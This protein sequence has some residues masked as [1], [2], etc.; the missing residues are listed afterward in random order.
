[1]S[2]DRPS[3]STSTEEE[4]SESR[5]P[6]V[7]HQVSKRMPSTHLWLKCVKIATAHTLWGLPTMK[8]YMVCKIQSLAAIYLKA[9]RQCLRDKHGAYDYVAGHKTRHSCWLGCSIP[10]FGAQSIHVFSFK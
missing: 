2:D 7:T 6:F 10:R 4:N 3:T 5:A 8:N 9:K 1:M